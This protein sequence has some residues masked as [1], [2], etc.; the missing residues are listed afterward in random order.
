MSLRRRPTAVLA[1]AVIAAALPATPA[2]AGPT[3]GA[4]PEAPAPPTAAAP[5]PTVAGALA[6]GTPVATSSANGITI[7]SRSA[8]L[9]RQRATVTG[10][11]PAQL[12]QLRIEQ[13]DAKLGWSPVATATIAADGTFAAAWRP[14]SVGAQQLRAVA[15]SSATRATEGAPQVAVTVFR[16]GLASWYG[17][18]FYGGKT[19]CGLKLRKATL[20]VA[21]KTLP[22]GTQVQLLYRGKT[23]TVPVIDRGPFIS[24]RSWDLTKATH[25]AL[26]G[27]DGLVTVGALALADQPLLK[28]PYRAPPVKG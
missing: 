19:A 7:T 8:T 18:G 14:R 2:L 13:L 5:D 23:M 27:L 4:S 20:G 1:A 9:L 25:T 24:G 3:G 28:T 26:G 22:C 16:T 15:A 10:V 21:H 12:G 11:A 17:P 6:I